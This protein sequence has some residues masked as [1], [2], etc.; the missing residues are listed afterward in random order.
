MAS[1][2]QT[3]RSELNTVDWEHCILVHSPHPSVGEDGTHW[4]K[5]ALLAGSL[6]RAE[7]LQL[8]SIPWLATAVGA[9][10]ADTQPV[11]WAFWAQVTCCLEVLL[12]RVRFDTSIHLRNVF[13]SIHLCFGSS[14]SCSFGQSRKFQTPR[15]F[16]FKAY[17]L[18]WTFDL[19]IS[20]RNRVDYLVFV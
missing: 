19:T 1:G 4:K 9:W 17:P 18:I 7:D 11:A 13:F 12:S 10:H 2:T 14:N 3:L 5:Y 15:Y 6:W 20:Q 8:H 16:L